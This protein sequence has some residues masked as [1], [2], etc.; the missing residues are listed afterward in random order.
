[1]KEESPT[2]VTILYMYMIETVVIMIIIGTMH[3]SML[4]DGK[5]KEKL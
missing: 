5:Y 2:I 1:M 4:K 3:V